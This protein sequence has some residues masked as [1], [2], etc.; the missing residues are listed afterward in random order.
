P[1]LLHFYEKLDDIY[2][3][4]KTKNIKS[5]S[6]KYYELV[7]F[8][9]SLEGLTKKD[10]SWMF[11]NLIKLKHAILFLRLLESIEDI[12]PLPKKEVE[13]TGI[14]HI[15]PDS[16]K[17]RSALYDQYTKLK[18]GL[19]LKELYKRAHGS[20]KKVSPK[21]IE[22]IKVKL[23]EYHKETLAEKERRLLHELKESVE[24]KKLKH[25]AHKRIERVKPSEIKLEKVK[26][27]IEIV[28]PVVKESTIEFNYKLSSVYKLIKENKLALAR[29][30]YES[31]IKFYNGLTETDP[32]IL[33]E[34]YSELIRLESELEAKLIK[35]RLRNVR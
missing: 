5:V 29:R 27:E 13:E 8:Y 4:I 18:S 33:A 10:S 35:K 17:I 7:E 32:K 11:F 23:P 16:S 28:K 20:I 9:N 19:N 25:E 6:K 24:L 30:K 34:M 3:L 1:Y 15:Q 26:R 14:K 31:T 22:L 21:Q 12:K 2:R